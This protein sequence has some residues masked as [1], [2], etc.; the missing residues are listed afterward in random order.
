MTD[1]REIPAAPLLAFIQAIAAIVAEGR[2]ILREETLTLAA[3]DTANVVMVRATIE[4]PG[5]CIGEEE[6]GV[7][8][9]KIHNFLKQVDPWGFVRLTR[10]GDYLLLSSVTPRLSL[11][12]TI[13]NLDLKTVRPSPRPPTLVLETG[14]V[15]EGLA[16][17]QATA[18]IA[19]ESDRVAIKAGLHIAEAEPPQVLLLEASPGKEIEARIPLKNSRGPEARAIFSVDYIK[20]LVKALKDEPEVSV[21][22]ATDHPLMLT[23]ARDGVMI[24]YMLAP[25]REVDE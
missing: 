18:A 24:E 8:I 7:D 19:M 20:D 23:V 5:R 1:T 17:H 13:K 25:R 10:A 11:G 15:V 12:A 14:G 21:A 6:I 9:T 4:A 22:L 16:L 2:L 3:V